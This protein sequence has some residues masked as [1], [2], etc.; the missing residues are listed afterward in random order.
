MGKIIKNGVVYGGTSNIAGN[1]SYDNTG[2]QLNAVTVQNAI[3]EL[4]TLVDAI[5]Y[6]VLH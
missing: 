3:T 6:V 5:N 4:K 1:I 2:T